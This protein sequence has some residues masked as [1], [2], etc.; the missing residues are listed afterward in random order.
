MSS[1]EYVAGRVRAALAEA[2]GN[3]SAARRI[4]IA[5]CGRDA[6]LMRGLVAPYLPGIVAH[7]VGQSSD[8]AAKPSKAELPA[9]VLE[10]VVGRLGKAIGETRL[11][12]GMTALTEPPSRPAAGARHQ[13]AIRQLADAYK[14]KRQAF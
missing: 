12:R 11:P 14:Q 8:E 1:K 5:E 2:K 6:R 9:N 3:A 13:E 7:A 4:L 10:T